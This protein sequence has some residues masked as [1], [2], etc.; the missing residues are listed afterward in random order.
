MN[1]LSPA[2]KVS[3]NFINS[4]F[5]SQAQSDST[6]DSNTS[7]KILNLSQDEFTIQ[8]EMIRTVH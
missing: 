4:K 7:D 2:T 8:S 3:L 6:T 1:H 5:S